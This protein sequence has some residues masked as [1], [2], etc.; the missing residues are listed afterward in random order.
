MSRTLAPG[1]Y[2]LGDLAPG[3]VIETG[4]VTVSAALIDAFAA[5]SGDRFEIHMDA[6]AAAR[7]GFAARVAHG[8]L[9]LSLVDG[10][11]NAAPAQLAARAS[12]GWDWRFAAPVLA[13]DTVA[14]RITVVATRPLRRAGQGVVELDVAVRNQRG[15]TVQ[16][17]TNRLL[18]YA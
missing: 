10:L 18:V 9:V 6:S 3:D 14:A 13:G 7:H 15:E 4:A 17:G 2:R 1:R 11:K 8:L 16:A 12:L 5:L